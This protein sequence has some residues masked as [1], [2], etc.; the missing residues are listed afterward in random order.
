MAFVLVIIHFTLGYFHN[1]KWLNPLKENL[2]M[3][4]IFFDFER[5]YKFI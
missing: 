4:S 5:I 3:L 2:I 1:K